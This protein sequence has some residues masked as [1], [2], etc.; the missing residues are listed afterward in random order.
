MLKEKKFSWEDIHSLTTNIAKNVTAPDVVFS[1]G[2]GGSIPGVILAEIFNVDNINLGYRSYTDR[3]RSGIVT[4]QTIDN[5]DPYVSKRILLVDDIADTGNTL[6]FALNYFKEKK[7]DKISVSTIFF[8]ERSLIRPDFYS[9]QV[10]NEDW[11]IFPW[12]ANEK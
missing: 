9:K 10:D 8:K 12:E 11:I 6:K 5:T 7:L 4:Y 1:L 2:K 3:N